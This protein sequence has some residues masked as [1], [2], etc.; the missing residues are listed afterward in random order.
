MPG[1]N[2]KP[3]SN[4]LN[5]FKRTIRRKSD[6]AALSPNQGIRDLLKTTL[7]RQLVCFICSLENN[8]AYRDINLL[9][10]HKYQ[11]RSVNVNILLEMKFFLLEIPF[12]SLSFL[13]VVLP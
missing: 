3:G 13:S 8:F 2:F 11:L 4:L 7:N 5:G 12:V 9:S 10:R 1:V 6:G